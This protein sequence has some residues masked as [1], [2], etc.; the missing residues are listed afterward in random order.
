M[1]RTAP[2]SHSKLFALVAGLAC[3]FALGGPVM[4]FAMHWYSGSEYVAFSAPG[5]YSL[6]QFFVLWLSARAS[7]AIAISAVLVGVWLLARRRAERDVAIR[8]LVAGVVLA[9][10]T[11]FAIG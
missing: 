4:E 10:G 9:A 5:G 2:N 11:Y 6:E 3:L 8:Y 7:Y 1:N